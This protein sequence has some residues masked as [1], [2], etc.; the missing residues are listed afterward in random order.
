MKKDIYI[1]LTPINTKLN[2]Q[3]NKFQLNLFLIKDNAEPALIAEV[4]VTKTNEVSF[5]KIDVISY[6]PS[7]TELLEMTKIQLKEFG[8]N[9]I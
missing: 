9:F 4:S 3:P 1:K 8:Y 7:L 2:K 5:S 6:M